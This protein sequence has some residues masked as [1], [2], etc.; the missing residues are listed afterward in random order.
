MD[1]RKLILDVKF[2]YVKDKRVYN[3]LSLSEKL[4]FKKLIKNKNERAN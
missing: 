3:N 1:L 2:S 4:R